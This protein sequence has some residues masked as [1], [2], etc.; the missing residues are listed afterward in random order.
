MTCFEATLQQSEILQAILTLFCVVT[1]RKEKKIDWC[2]YFP[3]VHLLWN[4]D[5]TRVV[6]NTAT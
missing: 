6:I 4:Y 1:Q 5:M 2:R 3:F